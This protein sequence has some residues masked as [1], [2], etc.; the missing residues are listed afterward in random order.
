MPPNSTFD[1]AVN[2]KWECPRAPVPKRKPAVLW[3][4]QGPVRGRAFKQAAKNVD[5]RSP[6]RSSGASYAIAKAMP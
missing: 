2:E 6:E 3:V 4:K 5:K 1:N